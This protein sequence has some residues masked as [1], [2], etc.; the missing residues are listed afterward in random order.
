MNDRQQSLELKAVLKH[1]TLGGLI[2][3]YNNWPLNVSILSYCHLERIIP[4]SGYYL[5]KK[6]NSF[7][8][9]VIVLVYIDSVH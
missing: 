9:V 7:V 8:L 2:V 5:K 1:S 4:I 6:L 3:L